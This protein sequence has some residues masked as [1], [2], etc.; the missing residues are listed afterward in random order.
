MFQTYDSYSKQAGNTG[1]ILPD[2]KDN[3]LRTHISQFQSK[4]AGG[5][6]RKRFTNKKGT[7]IRKKFRRARK[8]NRR[9]SSSRRYK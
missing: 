6:G 2:I 4:T 1:N 3:L 8:T 5:N 7:I 9:K